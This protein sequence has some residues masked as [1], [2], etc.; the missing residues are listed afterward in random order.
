MGQANAALPTNANVPISTPTPT[1]PQTAVPQTFTVFTPSG[2]IGQS[3]RQVDDEENDEEKSDEKTISKK[4]Q[5]PFAVFEAIRTETARPIQQNH[6]RHPKEPISK[7]EQRSVEFPSKESESEP[8]EMEPEQTQNVKAVEDILHAAAQ[9]M[10][11]QKKGESNQPDQ[12]RYLH[13]IAAACEAAAHYAPIRMKIHLDHLGTLALRFFYKSDKLAL[14]FET[15]SNKSAQF[16][17]DH[18]EGLQTILSRRNVKIVDIEIS[19]ESR[20]RNGMERPDQ[21]T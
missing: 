18:L 21:P 10:S 13:R 19:H 20:E 17:R 7:T 5:P 3:S 14:R 6:S 11:V 8:R 12:T 9:T 16:L 15:P 4:K 1:A 2:R